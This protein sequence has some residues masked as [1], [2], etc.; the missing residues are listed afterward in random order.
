MGEE[1]TMRAIVYDRYGAP[2]VLQVRE[3][4]S[5]VPRAV[6]QAHIETKRARGKVGVRIS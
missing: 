6:G 2:E 1:V 3:I 4:A 5:P